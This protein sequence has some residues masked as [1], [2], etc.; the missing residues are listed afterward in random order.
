[1]SLKGALF[2]YDWSH[3]QDVVR[4]LNQA[5]KYCFHGIWKR[6][7]FKALTP[8]PNGVEGHT[9]DSESKCLRHLVLPTQSAK[10]LT[11]QAP[12]NITEESAPACCRRTSRV[13]LRNRARWECLARFRLSGF[14]APV[15]YLRD[16]GIVLALHFLPVQNL[17]SVDGKLQTLIT[18]LTAL[19]G[20]EM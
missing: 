14:L 13:Q 19:L 20:S 12:S 11:T 6:V 1:M 18:D 4:L 8:Y 5:K 2:F 9:K 17:Q 16:E 7:I 15:S 10:S 3:F